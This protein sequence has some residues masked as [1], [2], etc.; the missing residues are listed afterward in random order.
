M[1]QNIV[2]KKRVMLMDKQRMTGSPHGSD[3]YDQRGRLYRSQLP[4]NAIAPGSFDG[5]DVFINR[6]DNH[7]T[8]HSTILDWLENRFCD[9]KITE[10]TFSFRNL[11]KETR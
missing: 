3:A 2:T 11:L 10:E 4:C 1:T 6:Y 7:L 9:P 5:A 8:A